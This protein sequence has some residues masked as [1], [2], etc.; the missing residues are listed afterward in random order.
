MGRLWAGVLFVLLSG[1]NLFSV[2]FLTD[3][4]DTTR[5]QILTVVRLIL[6][7]SFLVVAVGEFRRR[8]AVDAEGIHIIETIRRRTYPWQDV[9]EVRLG[10]PTLLGDAFVY[11]QRHG[12][13]QVELPNSGGHVRLLQR[14]HAAMSTR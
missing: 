13:K 12:A 3:D 11:V 1:A 4:Y 14:W 9:D 8:V 5:A 10:R 7:V 6:V 2:L